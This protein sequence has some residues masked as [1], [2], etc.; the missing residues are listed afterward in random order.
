MKERFYEDAVVVGKDFIV[1]GDGLGE[2]KGLSGVFS[3]HQCLNIARKLSE[4][5]PTKKEELTEAVFAASGSAASMIGIVDVHSSMDEVATTLVYMKIHK[6][7]LLSGVIG[8]SGF[9]IY[10]YDSAARMLKLVQRSKEK[11]WDFNIPFSVYRKGKDVPDEYEDDVEEGDVVIVASDGLLD[12]LP[13]SF[14]TAATNY[15]VYK[16]IEKTENR[17][18]LDDF[19]YDYDLAD[20][21]ERYV[22]NLSAVSVKLR[23]SMKEELHKKKI[24]DFNKENER[25]DSR[26]QNKYTDMT[27]NDPIDSKSYRYV[28][29]H[30]RLDNTLKELDDLKMKNFELEDFRQKKEESKAQFAPKIENANR[31][32]SMSQNAIDQKKNFKN[33]LSVSNPTQNKLTSKTLST[34]ASSNDELDPNSST[35]EKQPHQN[36]NQHSIRDQSSYNNKASWKEIDSNQQIDISMR[37]IFKYE[38]CNLFDPTT[39]SQVFTSFHSSYRLSNLSL[40]NI[41]GEPQKTKKQIDCFQNKEVEKKI[42]HDKYPS[43]WRC[44]DVSELIYPIHAIKGLN[45]DHH[46]FLDCVQK[47]IPVLPKWVTAADIAKSFNSRYFARNLALAVKYLANDKRVKLDNFMFKALHGRPDTAD[48]P[49]RQKMAED[50]EMWRAKEDDL[51]VAAAA[52]TSKDIFDEPLGEIDSPLPF[53]EDLLAHTFKLEFWLRYRAFPQSKIQII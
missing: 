42:T 21:V 19:D 11:V 38:I 12:V 49:L 34:D 36:P 39:S 23:G 28:T 18:S 40:R 26:F 35:E 44:K 25:I 45:G 20:F 53:R 7:K 51:S 9:S 43:T 27:T 16:M 32:A 10:R 1:L 22:E 50:R 4:C 29:P 46:S 14:I 33:K 6:T 30:Q 48:D 37:E 15:L 8:G 5:S 3:I 47:A 24:A 13:S 41:K 31:D 17:Q 2:T 52:I